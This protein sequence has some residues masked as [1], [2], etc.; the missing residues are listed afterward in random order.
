MN[1]I[2]ILLIKKPNLYWMAYMAAP[3]KRHLPFSSLS[4]A[5]FFPFDMV[6]GE[7]V[8]APFPNNSLQLEMALGKRKTGPMLCYLC[9]LISVM[10]MLV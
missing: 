8:S 9:K 10:S 1:K 4:F 7:G 5:P 3:K 2:E 6:N